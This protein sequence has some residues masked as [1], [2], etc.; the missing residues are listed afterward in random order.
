MN[1]LFV[2]IYSP[3]QDLLEEAQKHIPDCDYI[4]D[5]FDL[6][7]QWVSDKVLVETGFSMNEVLGMRN[8]DI[9]SDKYD[10]VTLRRELIERITQG[11]GQKQYN[12]KTKSRGELVCDF[13]YNTFSFNG[14]WYMAGKILKL[15]PV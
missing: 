10:E 6:K 8:I 14:V 12:I 11:K 1:K 9:V 7:F 4:V 5:L 13:A 3:P 2:I 15:N